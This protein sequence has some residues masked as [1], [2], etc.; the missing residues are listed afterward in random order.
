MKKV[1]KKV[2]VVHNAANDC[3]VIEVKEKLFGNW[4]YELSYKYH[5]EGRI[6]HTEHHVPKLTEDEA[7]A[8]AIERATA[9][10]NQTVIWEQ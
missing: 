4:W 7:R 9:L 10:R 3:F 6:Y 8:K 2:R 1:Y 5:V